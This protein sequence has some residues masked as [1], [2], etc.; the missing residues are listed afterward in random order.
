MVNINSLPNEILEI[1]FHFYLQIESQENFVNCVSRV[2][3]K[4]EKVAE[5]CLHFETLDGTLPLHLLLKLAKEGYLK[6]TKTLKFGKLDEQSDKNN[7]YRDIYNNMPKLKDLDVTNIDLLFKAEH[8]VFTELHQELCPDLCGLVFSL[9]EALYLATRS[10]GHKLVKLDF[11]SVLFSNTQLLYLHIG[12]N[13]PNLEELLV[14]NKSGMMHVHRFP[15]AIM[16][17]YCLKLKTLCLKCP[18][19]F[20]QRF[21]GM[22]N[23]FPN[24]E[25]FSN[26]S[27]EDFCFHPSDLQALLF[28]S[29]NL[30]V[31][32]IR[33]C[34]L[35]AHNAVYSLPA[36]NLEKLYLFWTRIAQTQSI[37]MIFNKWHHSLKVVDVGHVK[38]EIINKLFLPQFLP[39]GLSALEVLHVNNT[40][41][42]A[43]A[44]KIVIQR[45]PKLRFLNS[46]ACDRLR[47]DLRGKYRSRLEIEELLLLIAMIC[48]GEA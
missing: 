18:V 19:S 38:G 25:K 21:P 33:G 41:I 29:P 5:N 12:S 1:I 45:C 48:S 30:K 40:D 7:N 2:C 26:A 10:F 28:N 13:C 36:V 43:D 11:T 34:L 31:L 17:T 14:Q 22:T 8:A 46:E 32:D 35:V 39:D 24:L 3:Q 20:S 37:A 27:K 6:K 42:T 44:L 47:G 4:W 15:L 16:Q 9:P 23:G